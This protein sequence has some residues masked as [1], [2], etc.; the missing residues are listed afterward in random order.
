[1]RK[2]RKCENAQLYT[3]VSKCAPDFG[4]MKAAILVKPGVKLPAELSAEILEK[5]VHADRE[6]RIYGIVGLTEYALNGGE[7]QTAATGY[8]PEQ[9]TGVS[10]RKDTFDLD[11][12]YP[13]LDS[14]LMR[15]ANTE[16]DVY[17]IDEDYILHGIDDGTDTLAGYPMSSVYADSTPM[18]TS[19]ARATMQVVFCHADARLS[20]VQADYAP[21]GFKMNFKRETLG[22]LGVKLVKSD[23]TPNGYKIH[24]AVGGYDITPIYGPLIAM[25][26]E[27]VLNGGATAVTYDDVTETLTVVAPEDAMVSLK[28]PAVLYENDIKG[29]EQI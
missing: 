2:L 9:V 7:V 3:G 10:A 18:P 15:T 27:K 28:S 25:A 22:L 5:M 16:W 23:D 11:K 14:S 1:M 24:E 12:Y 26:G 19:S 13:E 4:K 6:E 8:G 17:F 20:K 29:I 21:L